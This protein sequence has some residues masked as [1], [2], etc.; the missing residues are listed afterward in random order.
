MRQLVSDDTDGAG[1]VEVRLSRGLKA[2]SFT[3]G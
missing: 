3:F 2:Y 1:H